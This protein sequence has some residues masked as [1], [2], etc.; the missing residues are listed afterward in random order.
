[1]QITD[2]TPLRIILGHVTLQPITLEQARSM[3]D[4]QSLQSVNRAVYEITA[5]PSYRGCGA[6]FNGTPVQVD[7]LTA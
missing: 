5:N 6:N 4:G 3:L 1:M 2:R 7:V